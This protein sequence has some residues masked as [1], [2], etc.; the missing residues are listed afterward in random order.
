M[1]CSTTFMTMRDTHLSA[2]SRS[3]KLNS[4]SHFSAAD[5]ERLL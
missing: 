1:A 3:R 2:V 5:G 4:N